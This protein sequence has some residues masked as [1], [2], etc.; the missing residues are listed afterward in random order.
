MNPELV[1]RCEKAIREL[2]E[3]AKRY[4][5][6]GNKVEY[7]RIMA[8]IEGVSLVLSY[9]RD[10]TQKVAYP[11]TDNQPYDEDEV[12]YGLSFKETGD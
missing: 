4:Y 6:D 12:P 8:K 5:A 10:Y 11:A 1:E 3:I 9:S 2:T 7:E